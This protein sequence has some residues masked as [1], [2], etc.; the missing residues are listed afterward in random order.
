MQNIPISQPLY[1][2]TMVQPMR[3]EVT[4]LGVMELRTPEDVDTALA[5]EG[6][7]L[8]F[9]N[10]VCGCAAG[11]ARPS[12]RMA[13]QNETLPD[14]MVTVFAGQD[15]EATEKARGYFHG[16]PPSSPQIVLMKD[17]KVAHMIQRHH[18]EGR[19]PEMIADNLKG[20]FDAFCKATA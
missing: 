13:L 12:L 5:Q 2:P 6:T 14:N 19:T 1:D 3:D 20:A 10:S 9:V 18:I 17:G 8:V 15:R 4:A 11:G 16:Y 7:T